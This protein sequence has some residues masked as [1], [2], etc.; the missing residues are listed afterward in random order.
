MPS[1]GFLQSHGWCSQRPMQALPWPLLQSELQLA[2][3]VLRAYLSASETKASGVTWLDI[4]SE[5]LR[6]KPPHMKVAPAMFKFIMN[7]AGGKSGHMLSA[8][9]AFV[10][11]C[12]VNKSLGFELWDCVSQESKGKSKIPRLLARHALKLAYLQE[13]VLVTCAEIKKLLAG[14]ELQ[15]QVDK[16]ESIILQIHKMGKGHEDA[17]S[18][19]TLVKLQGLAVPRQEAQ[20]RGV[21]SALTSSSA[22]TCMLET[23]NWRYPEP[24]CGFEG[25]RVYGW[26]D[27]VP[28]GRQ[29]HWE[30][31]ERGRWRTC[32]AHAG[33]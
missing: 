2:R 8:T 23:R 4:S 15:P 28:E 21:P 24:C 33:R 20:E 9:E 26:L 29:S 25:S 18:G 3:K 13:D 32:G 10:N 31:R 27:S 22:G 11:T 16:M 30:D 1:A 19:A 12:G 7:Y 17:C 14:K 5:V 6:S